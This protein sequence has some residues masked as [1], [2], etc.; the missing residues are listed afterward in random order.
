M[1]GEECL[2]S[3]SPDIMTQDPSS[4]KAVCLLPQ[5]ILFHGTEDSSVPSDARLV[6]IQLV[7]AFH[8]IQLI[9]LSL[10]QTPVDRVPL[11]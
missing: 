7:S 10:G 8:G 4:R 6:S 2:E 11:L 3:F 9:L 5:V 1:E